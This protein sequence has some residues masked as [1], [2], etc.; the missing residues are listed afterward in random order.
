MEANQDYSVERILEIYKNLVRNTEFVPREAVPSTNATYNALLSEVAEYNDGGKWFIKLC[1]E[2]ATLAEL[3]YQHCSPETRIL[4]AKF[5]WCL[6]N[7]ED[8]GHKYPESIVTF[9]PLILQRKEPE[10]K[11]LG[12][13]L[14]S[15]IAFYQTW[16]PIPANAMSHSVLEFINGVLLEQDPN[17][18]DMELSTAAK[19]WPYFLRRKTGI[20]AAFAFGIFPKELNIELPV[21]IQAI[22]DTVQ[23]ID[24]FNDVLSFHKE[25][26]SG[27][28]NNYINSRAR[29]N[30][31]TIVE[32]LQESAED[33]LAAYSRAKQILMGT[34]AYL[35]WKSCLDGYISF[36]FLAQKRYR[37]NELGFQ[38]DGSFQDREGSN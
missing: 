15:L 3:M 17:I 27:E 8:L 33:A 20:S 22:E 11:V 30:E 36:H 2:S 7:I 23:F 29:V 37:L 6:I 32:T 38:T 28:R 34:E 16:D 9:Q 21:Y 31:K 19:S 35:P 12:L 10:A 25:Y 4:M 26:Q 14:D 5:I 24:I 1:D 13:L 18:L